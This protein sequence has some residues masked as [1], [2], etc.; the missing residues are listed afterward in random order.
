L[1]VTTNESRSSFGALHDDDD[2]DDEEEE[3]GAVE[4]KDERKVRNLYEL[5]QRGDSPSL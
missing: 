1:T 2:D 5:C 3:E 4:G